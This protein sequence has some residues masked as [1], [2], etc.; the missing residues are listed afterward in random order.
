MKHLVCFFLVLASATPLW[1]AAC[2]SQEINP[3]TKRIYTTAADYEN[4]LRIWNEKAAPLP[5]P[6]NLLRAYSLYKRELPGLARLGNDK[7]QHCYMGCRIAQGTTRRTAVYVAW[8]KEIQDLT[9]C[10]RSSHF[11]NMDYLAT[12]HG[13]QLP[14]RSA[15]DCVTSCHAAWKR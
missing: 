15:E 5:N 6:L 3:E 8:Y 7:I 14:A 9:D 11:E 4:H 2:W 1:A 10:R 12:V 13:A